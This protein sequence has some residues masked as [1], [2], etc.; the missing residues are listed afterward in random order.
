MT[1]NEF[2]NF[3]ISFKGVSEE[4]PFDDRVVVYKVKGKIFALCDLDS[5]P[6]VPDW[7]ITYHTMILGSVTGFLYWKRNYHIEH[8]MFAAVP[9]FMNS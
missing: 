6:N 2:H 4:F 3:C 8:H 7:R 5:L 9:F 1:V